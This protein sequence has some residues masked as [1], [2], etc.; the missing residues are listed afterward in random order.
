[1]SHTLDQFPPPLPPLVGLA[2]S[3]VAPLV[4]GTSLFGVYIRVYDNEAGF[5]ILKVIIGIPKY[6]DFSD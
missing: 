1:M 4:A 2:G 6:T 3:V 5:W